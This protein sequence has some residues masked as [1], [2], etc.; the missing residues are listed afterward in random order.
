MVEYFD[1]HNATNPRVFGSVV[2]GDDTDESDLDILVDA[3][4]DKT[5]LVG[6]A[7]IQSAIE[8]LAGIQVDVMTPLDL[9]ERFRVQVIMEAQAARDAAGARF[10]IFKR[11][12][13]LVRSAGCLDVLKH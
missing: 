1:T 6:L 4:D 12:A 11:L 5:T 2:H 13:I 3:I 7:R 8:A 10:L 9:H